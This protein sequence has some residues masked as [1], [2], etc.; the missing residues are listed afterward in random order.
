MREPE[1]IEL[2]YQVEKY[3]SRWN[4]IRMGAG[5][6]LYCANKSTRQIYRVVDGYVSGP[7]RG[8]L[9]ENVTSQFKEE[10]IEELCG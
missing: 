2:A 3:D 1:E 6:V 7:V 9:G 10:E 8:F 4:E 5:T